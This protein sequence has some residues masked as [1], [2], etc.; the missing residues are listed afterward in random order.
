MVNA[1]RKATCPIRGNT[2]DQEPNRNELPKRKS[3]TQI[4]RN[5][6]VSIAP[7]LHRHESQKGSKTHPKMY[8]NE[9]R[10]TKPEGGRFLASC[11]GVCGAI[12]G[13]ILEHIWL[14]VLICFF[15][16]VFSESKQAF[17]EY[18]RFASTRARFGNAQKRFRAS[19]SRHKRGPEAPEN[20]K[21]KQ[22]SKGPRME[23]ATLVQ[24][25]QIPYN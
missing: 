6:E 11:E 21:T 4:K 19:C 23:K 16:H 15:G 25:P 13:L 10:S 3:Q 22:R 8:Q 7:F 14:S 9:P 2:G 1:R 17:V 18:N 24:V 20:A 12:L 5:R